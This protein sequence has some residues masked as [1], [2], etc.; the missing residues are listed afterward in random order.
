MG[1]QVGHEPDRPA[2]DGFFS[3]WQGTPPFD[4]RALLQWTHGLYDDYLRFFGARGVTYNVFLRRN[5]VNPG[6][7]VEVANSFVGTYDDGTPVEDFKLTLAH[8]MVHTFV[9]ALDE[10]DELA[11]SW[12]AEGLA[13]YYQRLLPYRAGVREQAVLADGT[14]AH[15]FLIEATARTLH[16]CNAPSPA[17][18]SSIPIARHIVE[19]AVTLFDLHA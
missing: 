7:G 5:K 2:A 8:E 13:V 15:D 14:L 17:A 18:T 10:K 12:F 4:A 16:V 1:G 6:G 19:R 3:A 11:A 9:G